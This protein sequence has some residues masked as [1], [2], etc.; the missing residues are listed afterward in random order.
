MTVTSS[1][2]DNVVSATQHP[3]KSNA[4]IPK[5]KMQ[6]KKSSTINYLNFLENQNL[7]LNVIMKDRITVTEENMQMN[8]MNPGKHLLV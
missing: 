2:G 4:G 1:V 6:V 8:I 7:V 5:Q 3:F